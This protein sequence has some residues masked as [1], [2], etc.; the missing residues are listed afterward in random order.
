MTVLHTGTEPASNAQQTQSFPLPAFATIRDWCRL[1]GV[2]RSVTYELLAAGHLHARKVGA[3]TLVD[4]HAGIQWLDRQPLAR[5]RP[6]GNA[7]RSN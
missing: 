6:H 4:V 5:I 1:S 2:S 3:R 7:R